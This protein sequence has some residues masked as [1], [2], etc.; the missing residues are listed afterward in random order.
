MSIVELMP[1]P[2]CR[3]A[4]INPGSSMISTNNRVTS[5]TIHP[6][7]TNDVPQKV[8][9]TTG[10]RKLHN[11]PGMIGNPQR[12]Y[13]AHTSRRRLFPKDPVGYGPDAG[14]K[15]LFDQ[16]CAGHRNPCMRFLSHTGTR[17]HSNACSEA[18]VLRKLRYASVHQKNFSTNDPI[19]NADVTTTPA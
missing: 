17:M 15:R 14:L 9:R 1:G 2:R 13:G 12:K 10:F 8:A 7:A 3:S 18:L 11:P 6:R 5:R 4:C 19:R 16:A